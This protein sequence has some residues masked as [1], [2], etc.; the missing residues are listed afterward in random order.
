MTAT[1]PP[2]LIELSSSYQSLKTQQNLTMG[3]PLDLK[4]SCIL[5]REARY[6]ILIDLWGHAFKLKEYINNESQFSPY[7]TYYEHECQQTTV[8]GVLPFSK[9]RQVLDAIVTI[10]TARSQPYNELLELLGTKFLAFKEA[11]R[12]DQNLGVTLC[13]RLWL[14]INV[15]DPTVDGNIVPGARNVIRI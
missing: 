6:T 3:D 11:S 4:L 5:S 9:H 2:I 1:E 15:R 12:S 14:M 10:S 8:G 7:F 13:L